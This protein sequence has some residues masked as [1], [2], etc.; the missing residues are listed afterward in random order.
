MSEETS[1]HALS[2]DPLAFYIAL[3]RIHVLSSFFR[4]EHIRSPGPDC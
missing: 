2:R 3:Q 1:A 4:N